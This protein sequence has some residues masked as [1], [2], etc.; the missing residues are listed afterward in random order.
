[1]Q[2]DI[3]KALQFATK[4]HEGQVRKFDKTPYITHP[5][6]VADVLKLYAP[7][8]D[9][10]P[11]LIAS[12]Y[13]HD[14]LEDTD[15]SFK[16]LKENFGLEVARIVMEL[17]TAPFLSDKVKTSYLCHHMK[18]MSSP[19][20]TVKLADRLDNVSDLANFQKSKMAEK[21]DQTAKMIAS[22]QKTRRLNGVQQTL[23]KLIKNQLEE[24]R[25]I[26]KEN[27]NQIL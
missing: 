2:V 25:R 4:K 22:V 26:L 17:S 8:N 16:E 1:M 23:I 3:V 15:T 19:A 9:E 24:C 6:R 18:L 11:I 12:A 13:L 21:I 10:L 7:D 20:L 14:T 5:I 27:Q